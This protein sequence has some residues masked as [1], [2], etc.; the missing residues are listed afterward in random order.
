MAVKKDPGKPL[1]DHIDSG[2]M[3]HSVLYMIVGVVIGIIL[4]G[5]IL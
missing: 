4:F 1:D 5:F 2:M 3:L